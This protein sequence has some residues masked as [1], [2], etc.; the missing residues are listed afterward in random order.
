MQYCALE[1]ADCHVGLRPSPHSNFCL[2]LC[3]HMDMH[4]YICIHVF[5]V[6]DRLLA[7][8]LPLVAAHDQWCGLHK[9]WHIRLQGN[10]ALMIAASKGHTDIIMKLLRCGA[11]RDAVNG[12]ASV[13][14]ILL[15]YT[16]AFKRS[17][18][19]A[20]SPNVIFS[21]HSSVNHV[22]INV[23]NAAACLLTT[24]SCIAFAAMQGCNAA[25]C[26]TQ[27]RHTSASQVLRSWFPRRTR[28]RFGPASGL[29]D[30]TGVQ[31]ASAGPTPTSVVTS[32][33]TAVGSVPSTT[34]PT[35]QVPSQSRPVSTSSGIST[36]LYQLLLTVNGT[37]C[38]DNHP[39]HE[40]TSLHQQFHLST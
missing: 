33:S 30:N 29:N 31:S 18:H 2:L 22:K 9:I 38:L 7:Q 15:L 11:M 32:V 36:K 26:A 25:R 21:L 39:A 34:G 12:E 10:T 6:A 35:L 4:L 27:K 14:S 19:A 1:A 37:K 20:I 23:Y 28:C 17:S 3:P 40:R 16:L 24:T 13:Q 8:L 5:T